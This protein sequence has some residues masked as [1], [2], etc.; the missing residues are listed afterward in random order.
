MVGFKDY[1]KQINETLV[2]VNKG[3]KQEQAVIVV[4]GA[5]SG[6]GYVVSNFMNSESYKIF[7]VDDLKKR[8]VKL[9]SIKKKYPDIETLDLR[10]PEDVSRLHGIVKQEKLDDRYLELML[11]AASSQ[12]DLPNL[13]FDKTGKDVADVERVST[14]LVDIGYD[15]KNIHIIWV[16]S[17]YAVAINQNAGRSRVVPADIMLST[18]TGAAKTM[19]SIITNDLPKNMNG[20]LYIILGGVNNTA[21]YKDKK[22][23]AIL[24]SGSGIG[25]Y[26]SKPTMIPMKRGGFQYVKIKSSGKSI[27]KESNIQKQVKQWI[28]DNVPRSTELNDLFTSIG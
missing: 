18:H 21:F 19:Y 9:T 10:E 2:I 24:S 4:G 23:N 5:G 17:N 20:E 12:H 3:K 1:I 6:K 13:L 22:G 14:K 25:K 28:H 26:P 15:P 11:G 16:L 27:E 7:D 8:V